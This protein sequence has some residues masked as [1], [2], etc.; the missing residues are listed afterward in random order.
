MGLREMM[1][2]EELELFKDKYCKLILSNGFGYCGYIKQITEE[3][4]FFEDRFDG[5]KI[6]DIS[7]IKSI[8]EVRGEI[9][10]K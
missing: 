7:I 1:R 4:L 8:G 9:N 10:E 5:L 6:F 2:K 3:T